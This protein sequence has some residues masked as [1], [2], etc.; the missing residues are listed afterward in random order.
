MKSQPISA[1]LHQV[2]KEIQE[3]T[4][5]DGLNHLYN[6]AEELETKLQQIEEHS[7]ATK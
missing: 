5:P 6:Q 4:D 7:A 1:Q 3:A 2:S